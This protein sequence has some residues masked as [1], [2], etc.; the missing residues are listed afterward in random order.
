MIKEEINN[1][2]N[3]NPVDEPLQLPIYDGSIDNRR[4]KRAK[5]TYKSR[6]VDQNPSQSPLKTRGQRVKTDTELYNK[7]NNKNSNKSPT[8]VS[9]NN[10]NV[11]NPLLMTAIANNINKSNNNSSFSTY[12]E[13]KNNDDEDDVEN[14]NISGWLGF[15]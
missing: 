6:E 1:L 14:M 3:H 11:N 10:N 4:I 13:K 2:E 12:R 7:I 9:S 8:T 15:K 5:R